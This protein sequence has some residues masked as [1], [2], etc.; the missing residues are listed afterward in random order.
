M[1]LTITGAQRD[2]IYQV[3][4]NHLGGIDVV[5]LSVRAGDFAAAERQWSEFAA[6]LRLLGDLGW[7]ETSD[8]ETIVLS[9]PPVDLAR[10]LARLHKD[11]SGSLGSYVSRAKDDEA[12]AERDLLASEALGELLGQLAQ[13]VEAGEVTS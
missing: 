9:V 13:P 1:A 4:L 8:R 5:W 3:A 7:G 10:T 2:A 11:A 12:I 6:D